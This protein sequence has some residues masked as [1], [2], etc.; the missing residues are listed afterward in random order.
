MRRNA[1]KYFIGY[2][3]VL[4]F[5]SLVMNKDLQKVHK[6]LE[7]I[8]VELR[9]FYLTG[10]SRL[11]G[12]FDMGTGYPTQVPS[13]KYSKEILKDNIINFS[14][15]I[16]FYIRCSEDEEENKVR[17]ESICWLSNE[18]IAKSILTTHDPNRFEIALRC[19]IAF[20]DAIVDKDNGIF[21]GKPIIDAY[22][23]S[24][25]Q[26]WMGG[27][28]HPSVPIEYKEKLLGYDKEL[29]IYPVPFELKENVKSTYNVDLKYS[30]NW[31]KHHPSLPNYFPNLK[32]LG[33]TLSDI[34]G[35]V[36]RYKWESKD[37]YVKGRNTLDFVRRIDEEWNTACNVTNG[38]DRL[39][40]SPPWYAI[41]TN[42][43]V[44][45]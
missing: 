44:K 20:G 31:V 32:R 6:S 33:P 26:Q 38:T 1:G 10:M 7:T 12:S 17:F 9:N 8:L 27:A 21:T 45:N 25:C 24:E 18:F 35:H 11:Y 16:I 34:G 19:G 23:L 3:D 28:I 15:S 29:F 43:L 36:A 41:G 37:N 39:F 42:P 30:L 22:D 13:H 4:G 5:R 14:D 2:M 40:N